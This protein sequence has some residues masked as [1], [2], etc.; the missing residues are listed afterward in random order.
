MDAASWRIWEGS[1][2]VPTYDP[3]GLRAGFIQSCCC[4]NWY[5]LRSPVAATCAECCVSC[6]CTRSVQLD[7][8]DE[9]LPLMQSVHPDCPSQYK[10]VYWLRD[11]T[12]PSSLIT[13]HDADWVSDRLAYKSLTKN[14]VKASTCA[15]SL[16]TFMFLI[17]DKL[18][19]KLKVQVSPNRRW[20]LFSYPFLCCGKELFELPVKH[21]TY[22]FVSGGTLYSPSGKII[23]IQRGDMIRL[24]FAKWDDPASEVTYMYLIQRIYLENPPGQGAR[25]EATQEMQ[26]RVRV[27]GSENFWMSCDKNKSLIKPHLSPN[28]HIV[29]V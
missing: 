26:R 29:R 15:G 7:N 25:F 28:Q 13:L 11:L 18:G 5:G 8:L 4:I 17:G 19:G 6:M 10:G 3:H 27:E 12:Q 16:S 22:V 1:A 14:W 21:W 9:L 23:N 2:K 20:I 24:D